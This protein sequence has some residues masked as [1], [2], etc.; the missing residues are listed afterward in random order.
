MVPGYYQESSSENGWL[1]P[2]ESYHRAVGLAHAARGLYLRN[3]A[4][5]FGHHLRDR[6]CTWARAHHFRFCPLCC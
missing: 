2:W 1:P 4:T 5:A 3:A 6:F